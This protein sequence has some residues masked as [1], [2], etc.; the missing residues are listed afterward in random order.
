MVDYSGY[1]SCI[2]GWGFVLFS[3]KN[4]NR[5]TPTPDAASV[6]EQYQRRHSFEVSL[7]LS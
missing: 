7:Y 3:Q 6:T 1:E 2:L 4:I 5:A